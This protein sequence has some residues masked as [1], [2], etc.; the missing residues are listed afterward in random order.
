MKLAETV[1]QVAAIVKQEKVIEKTFNLFKREA[2][3][4]QNYQV[5]K[6]YTLFEF[7]QHYLKTLS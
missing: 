1:S 7:Q 6:F 5:L 4:R 3:V 2:F